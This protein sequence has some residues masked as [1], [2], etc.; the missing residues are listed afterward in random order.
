M[1][2]G[3]KTFDT[4]L[5]PYAWNNNAHVL[6]LENPPGVGFSQNDDKS[7]EYNENN[8]AANAYLALVEWF[9][10]F[11]EFKS[12]DFWITGESY[13][14]MYIPYLANEIIN[15]N[16]QAKPEDQIKLKGIMIGNGVMLTNTNWRR[17]A[18]DTFYGRHQFY[19]PEITSMMKTCKYN[20]EDKTKPS[21][22]QAEKLSDKVLA[23]AIIGCSRG[24]SLCNHRIVLWYSHSRAHHLLEIP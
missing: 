12:K 7:F 1:Q 14:G 15:R 5:N 16:S 18:R 22:V 3:A 2:P 20:D 19:G 4:T 8:T 11:P 24:E 13:C 17:Q 9:K 10:R 21:C 23:C 6:F